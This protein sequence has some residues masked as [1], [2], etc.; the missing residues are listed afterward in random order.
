MTTTPVPFDAHRRT[1]ERGSQRAWC[2]LIAVCGALAG[3]ALVRAHDLRRI[4][5]LPDGGLAETH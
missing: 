4:R 3:F 2:A 1:S 5:S